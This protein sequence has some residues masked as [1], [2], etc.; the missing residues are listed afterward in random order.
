ME[1]AGKV[2]GLEGSLVGPCSRERTTLKSKTNSVKIEIC[3]AV[4]YSAFDRN[5][6]V[7]SHSKRSSM[8]ARKK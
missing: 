3:D 7:S 4:F 8:N 6:V 1:G 5:N 2:M